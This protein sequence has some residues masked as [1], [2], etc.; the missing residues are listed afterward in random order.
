M[1]E[2]IDLKLVI[3]WF[4]ATQK[5]LL[6]SYE[7]LR[8]HPINWE[9][10]SGDKGCI[11]VDRELWMFRT[12]GAGITFK[13][14]DGVVVTAHDNPTIPDGFDSWRITKYIESSGLTDELS[15]IDIDSELKTLCDLGEII[16][17]DDPRFF[18]AK[19]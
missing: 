6:S 16:S 12:H 18:R 3:G 10:N 13:N 11:E 1:S 9:Q 19:C 4:I 15:G 5:R 7:N 2:T 14:W 8:R 17:T